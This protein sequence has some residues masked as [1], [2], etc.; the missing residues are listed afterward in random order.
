MSETL[1]SEPVHYSPNRSLGPCMRST[2]VRVYSRGSTQ[3]FEFS[4]PT[5]SPIWP[6]K[7]AIFTSNCLRVLQDAVVQSVCSLG[8]SATRP[9]A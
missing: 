9:S 3:R 8:R 5:F 4:R 7:C 1:R 6:S 2:V